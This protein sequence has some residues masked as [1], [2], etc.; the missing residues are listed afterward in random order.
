MKA[1]NGKYNFDLPDRE[2]TVGEYIIFKKIEY[3]VS[4]ILTN[5][6]VVLTFVRSCLTSVGA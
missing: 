6:K 1:T 5:G 3:R 4:K 2:Y